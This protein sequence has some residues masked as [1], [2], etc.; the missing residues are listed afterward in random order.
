MKK[1]WVIADVHGCAKS[2]QHLIEEQIGLGLKDELYLLGDYIDRG[3]D[4]KG[5]IDY[6]MDLQAKSYQVFPIKGN[7]EDVLLRCHAHE[8]TKPQPIG[9]YELKDGWLY[10]GGKATLKSFGV[11]DILDIPP[12]YISFMENLPY[13]YELEHFVLCHAGL[14]FDLEDPFS[15]K[16]SMLWI[17]DYRI[18][19]AKIQN[20]RLI[21]GHVPHALSTILSNISQADTISL[22]N[23]CV[24]DKKGKGNLIALELNTLELKVQPN[25]DKTIRKKMQITLAA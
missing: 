11:K 3:P 19:K 18:D 12:K 22:D 2:L 9:L 1:Q 7:H 21:H 24:Y 23:G 20:R 8:L 10:F 4:S 17:K 13:Y 5:V 16:L 25:L 6:I 14:N 15:D